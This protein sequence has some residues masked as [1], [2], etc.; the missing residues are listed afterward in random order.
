[1]GTSYSPIS[2]L[3]LPVKVLEC[4]MQPELNLLPLLPNQHGFRPIHSTVSTLLLFA[5]KIAQDFNQPCPTLTN[6]IYLTKAFDVVNQSKLIG[7]LTLSSLSN[8]TIIA[9]WIENPIR[10]TSERIHIRNS[11]W[12]KCKRIYNLNSMTMQIR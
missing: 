9:H 2:L 10:W 8:N 5:N 1:M 6:T 7:T 4:L 3:C 11:K 12:R